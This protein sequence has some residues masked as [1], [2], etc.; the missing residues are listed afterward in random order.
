MRIARSIR[1]TKVAVAVGL[2]IATMIS[3]TPPASASTLTFTSLTCQ[4]RRGELACEA[5]FSG[6]T[7]G[8]TYFWN[9]STRFRTDYA[10]HTKAWVVCDGVNTTVAVFA[11]DSSGATASVNRVVDCIYGTS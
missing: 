3:S 10:D 7:G 1:S 2:G 5:Y 6:G 8:N 9:Q 11:T 4:G